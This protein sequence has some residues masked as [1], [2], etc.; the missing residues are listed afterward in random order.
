MQ[1]TR[2]MRPT[3]NYFFSLLLALLTTGMAFSQ[4][5]VK[6]ADTVKSRFLPTGLRLGTDVI[7][8]I[9]SRIGTDFNGWEVNADVDFYRYY[10]TVDY[11]AWS[12]QEVMRNGDYNNDGTYFRVGADVNFMLKDP[13]RNML[14]IGF[15]YGHSVFN[16]TVNYTDSMSSFGPISKSIS[17]PSLQGHWGEL[18]TGLRV[19]IFPG[20]WMGYTARMK[21]APGVKGAGDLV[22]F[23]MP[24]YGLLSKAP[25]WGF[26]YQIFWRIPFRKIPAPA[27]K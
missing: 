14:F 20:F 24:G 2:P 23:D 1:S 26:N 17:N 7:S 19:K 16:E 25:Y 11:G 18:T 9:K 5:K 4:D 12:R 10:L 21:F 3:S 15:R 6:A 8:I 22:P 13:D 27:K